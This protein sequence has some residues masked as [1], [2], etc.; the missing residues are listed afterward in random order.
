MT[1]RFLSVLVAGALALSP[2]CGVAAPTVKNATLF[3]P[4]PPYI[5]GCTWGVPKPPAGYLYDFEDP[6]FFT[7][8]AA[9]SWQIRDNGLAP[10]WGSVSGLIQP[11]NGVYPVRPPWRVAGVDCYLGPDWRLY[12]TATSRFGAWKNP[13]T[14]A[15]PTGC[16]KTAFTALKPDGVTQLYDVSCTSTHAG[17]FDMEG[18]NFS[19]A[20]T[21]QKGGVPFYINA[22]MTGT[23]FV[24]ANNVL[25]PDTNGTFFNQNTDMYIYGGFKNIYIRNNYIDAGWNSHLYGY[26]L[27][28]NLDL[29]TQPNIYIE[30]NYIAHSGSRPMSTALV[31]PNCPGNNYIAG[32]FIDGF[33]YSGYGQHGDFPQTACSSTGATGT[34]TVAHLFNTVV[35]GDAANGSIGWNTAVV[36]PLNNLNTT[37]MVLQPSSIGNTIVTNITYASFAG[38]VASG[39]L[40]VTAPVAQAPGNTYNGMLQDGSFLY[41]P[42]AFIGDITGFG[43]ANGYEGEYTT[44]ITGT[45]STMFAGSQ[46][47][48]DTCEGSV[49]LTPV[50]C[51]IGNGFETANQSQSAVGNVLTIVSN[52]QTTPLQVGETITD[53]TS[54][55]GYNLIGGGGYTVTMPSSFATGS[56]AFGGRGVYPVSAGSYSGTITLLSTTAGSFWWAAPAGASVARAIFRDNYIDCSGIFYAIATP[57]TWTAAST[58]VNDG[59]ID[60]NNGH[61]LLAGTLPPTS[62][63][64][65]DAGQFV[66]QGSG[67][68]PINPAFD[69]GPNGIFTPGVF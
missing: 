69:V 9:N 3:A 40:T 31:G 47:N 46:S 5:D 29:Y 6:G 32:N 8:D 23:N 15:L 63:V 52:T 25:A 10:G 43:T 21:G 11:H 54:I 2:L 44:T 56:I 4:P 24:F 1:H 38:V 61:P 34:L 36:T 16:A 14:A 62:Q 48:P 18:Y 22:N 33:Q 66:A 59:N 60:L 27:T 26:R 13:L 51:F 55:G 41:S 50:Q 64:A 49:S 57:S 20:F 45:G 53:P 17:N 35:L 7:G 68:G 58:M 19:E 12:G 39:T 28:T 67:S 42:T 65:C 30:G 37:T